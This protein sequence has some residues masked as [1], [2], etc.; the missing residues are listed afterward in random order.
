MC[1]ANDSIDEEFSHPSFDGYRL[2]IRNPAICDPS[3]LQHS[4]YLDI[5]ENKHIFFWFVRLFW[6]LHCK[7]STESRFFESRSSPQEDPLVLWLNGGPGCSSTTGLLFELGPCSIEENGTSTRYNPHSWNS[8]A[9]IFFL[10]QPIDVGYSYGDKGAGRIN[11]TPAAAADVFAFLQLFIH[12]FTKYAELPFHIAAES[13]GG[14][15][16]PHIASIIHKSNKQL[17]YAPSPKLKRINLESILLGNGLTDPLIQMPS[18]VKYACEGPFA[19]FDD[20]N[21][22]ECMYLRQRAPVCERL[23]KACYKFDVRVACEPAALYCWTALFG[24][25]YGE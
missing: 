12:R 5:A 4:G 9:N 20:P 22:Q 17:V 24:P 7:P 11:N 16:A 8:K 18:V 19:V 10:D 25:L 3:V 23:I 6:L 21:G 2:R 1:C 13:Y 15:Y 14:A